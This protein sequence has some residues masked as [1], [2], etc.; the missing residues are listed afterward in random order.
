MTVFQ[1]IPDQQRGTLV[2]RLRSWEL[3]KTKEL[4]PMGSLL[5]YCTLT[6]TTA[7]PASCEWSTRSTLNGT[8][9]LNWTASAMATWF[10]N[11]ISDIKSK[12]KRW[13]KVFKRDWSEPKII[14][15]TRLCRVSQ[16]AKTR[17]VQ[18]GIVR[19]ASLE[20][21]SLTCQGRLKNKSSIKDLKSRFWPLWELGTKRTKVPT[22]EDQTNSTLLF[23]TWPS[24]LALRCSCLIWPV[25]TTCWRISTRSSCRRVLFSPCSFHSICPFT[26]FQPQSLQF[27]TI[28]SS[29][30]QKRFQQVS[31]KTLT[32]R[33]PTLLTSN[34]KRRWP[35]TTGLSL[36]NR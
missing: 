31:P 30:F 29:R 14:S 5:M 26:N 12:V 9:T 11:M 10:S 22:C 24:R 2:S 23:A 6:Q 18:N 21:E 4:M 16:L 32:I 20:A 35:T 15:L 33:Q 34:T 27:Q 19:T 8:A 1:S 7:W 17:T 36:C 13:S 3:P 28:W 25:S